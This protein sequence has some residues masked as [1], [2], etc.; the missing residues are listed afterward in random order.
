ML[1]PRPSAL[2]VGEGVFEL[3]RITRITAPAELAGAASWL[4]NA[5]RPATGFPLETGPNG[6][7]VLEWNPELA[8]EG[9]TLEVTPV[10]IRISGGG[11]AGVFY[12]CQSLVQLLPPQIYRR[13]RVLGVP[14]TVP[15]V[16]I[17]D[18]PRFRWRGAMLDVA[19]HFM[20]K[21]DVL[22]FIDLMAMHRLNTLHLHLTD[23]QGWR[24]EIKKYPKLT[25]IGS[26]RRESQLGAA[27]YSRGDSRPH[28]GFY[29]QDDLRE[30]V[31]YATDRAINVVPEID[32]PGH[33]QAAIAAY[34]ELGLAR[35]ESESLGVWTRW[36]IDDNVINLEESTVDFF[37]D[38]L[39]EVMEIFPSPFIGVGGDECPKNGWRLDERTQQRKQE[40]GLANEDE[41]QAWFIGRLDDHLSRRGR[42]LFGWDEIL[43]GGTTK[44]GKGATVASWR[45][46]TGAV[47]AAKAG[48]DVV[49]C[50]DDQVYLDYRQS[51]RTEEP[52]PVG[53]VLTIS[54]VYRFEPVPEQLTPE[55]AAH[56][57]GGQ[58]NIWTEHMDSPRTVDYFAFPRLCA[59]AEALWFD[60]ERDY[61]DF[62]FRLDQHLLRLDAIGVEYRHSTGPLPWQQRPGVTGR[63][64]TPQQRASYFNP[65]TAKIGGEVGTGSV[66]GS[67]SLLGDF[68]SSWL[69]SAST[70]G[71][72]ST[73]TAGLRSLDSTEAPDADEASDSPE[74]T[75]SD[76]STPSSRPARP[77]RWGRSSGS[78]GLLGSLGFSR[79]SK[80]DDD[81]DEGEPSD[82]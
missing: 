81:D 5:L 16:S 36:G 48:H 37:T 78:S 7:I 38:V 19:R 1:L 46:M 50:P 59:L 13:G 23:D 57:L 58:G 69:G 71:L 18:A 12:G 20:P 22:R 75:D 56:V 66:G 29:T 60:G 15:V 32:S 63:A 82:R 9:Y 77:S 52:I 34:P 54:D 55:E 41:L 24:V 47:A 68:G 43:E 30:I 17:Q 51:D 73:S 80:T 64:Q 27:S 11:P 21:H 62:L 35:E 31:G 42:R 40:L 72:G 26:W 39:D 28:G 14:W 25:E 6:A 44:L 10:D 53:T 76:D 74:S 61:D 70:P 45:G 67:G 3:S 49:S 33:T 8:P 79:S 2:A 65:L 4:Q